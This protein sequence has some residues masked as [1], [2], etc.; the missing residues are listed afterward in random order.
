L[1]IAVY[2]WQRRDRLAVFWFA[3][4]MLAVAE[5]VST[6]A[7]ISLSK[8]PQQARFWVNPHYFGLTLMVALFI[9][10]AATYTGRERWLTKFNKIV[11]F[12]IPFLTQLVIETNEAHHWFINDIQ[13]TPDGILMGLSHIEYGWF[14]GF[15]SIYSY[16]LVL[17][18]IG[19]ILQKSIHTFRLYRQQS[20]ILIIGILLPLLASLNDSRLFGFSF[21]YPLVPLGFALMGMSLAWALFRHQMLRIVPVA[22]DVLFESLDDSI[23]VLDVDGH[24]VDL[25]PAAEALIAM[26]ASQI[27]GQSA[28]VVFHQWHDVIESFR[29]QHTAH[30][31][32]TLTQNEQTSDYELRISPLKDRQGKVGGRI[33]ILRNITVQKK[34]Q[35]NAFSL[36]VE[37]ERSRILGQFVQNASHEFRSPLAIINTDLFLLSKVTDVEKCKNYV[38]RSQ[39]QITRL[40]QL[41]DMILAMTKL[42]SGISFD[43]QRGNL[44]LLLQTIIVGFETAVTQKNL[45]LLFKPDPLLPEIKMDQRWL[46]E[47]LQQLLGNAIRFTSDGGL[48]EIYTCQRADQAI[49]ALKDNGPGMDKAMQAH[50]FE[51]FWRYDESHTTPGFGLGLPIAQK[52]I[53]M[54]GGTIE[55]VSTKRMGSTFIVKLPI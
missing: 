55:V 2:A 8:T 39:E 13:F 12:S 42:D 45:Q 18:G 51:R 29:H 27:I 36:T 31:E 47:A 1:V 3:G 30:T 38:R 10:F 52:V 46:Q 20:L 37:Q 14:F 50:I 9:T 24:I 21:P 17:L 7:L 35:A 43:F 11:V 4:M 54:H 6:S 44:N 19:L 15:H 26:D 28:A 40:T 22:R 41:L 23:I 33:I 25:N 32:V 49:I 5:Y 53:E 48:I 34:L 16:A